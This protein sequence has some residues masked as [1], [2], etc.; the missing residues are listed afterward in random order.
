[1]NTILSVKNLS[2]TFSFPKEFPA[3]GQ[4]HALDSVSF[5]LEQGQT[6]AVLGENGSGKS[7]L[8]G[9]LAGMIVPSSGRISVANK[10]LV[11]GDYCQR[12]RLLRIIFQ[13]PERSFDPKL[14]VGQ[15]LDLPLKMHFPL[16]RTA[17]LKIIYDTLEQVG[18]MADHIDYYPLQMASGQKQRVALARALILKPK[19]IVADEAFSS[20]DISMRA[21]MIN[22]LLELQRKVNLS[23]VFIT[24]DV[25]LIKHIS[26][27]LLV[28]DHGKVAEYNDTAK[29]F[30]HPQTE[31]TR[32]LVNS[33]FEDRRN[34]EIWYKPY[35][36]CY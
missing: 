22:L 29:I 27:Q 31:I 13:N 25:A 3:T 10:R 23:Y 24:Q 7:T 35:T 5:S 6:L 17:R 21:Q 36:P 33:Y 11:F 26:D 9:L 34:T 2:K 15:L 12:S 28:L 4:K 20:L 14:K 1:M 16:S 32:R 30:A 8:A 18:L 19:V